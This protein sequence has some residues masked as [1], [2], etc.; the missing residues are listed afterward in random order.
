MA[1]D[2][3]E[4]FRDRVR[5]VDEALEARLPSDASAPEKVHEAMRYAVFGGGKRLRPM[6]LLAATEA[7]GHRPEAFFEAACAVELAHTTSLILDD[8][9]C[10]DDAALR[11]GRPC[12]HKKYGD[13]TAILAA[14]ALLSESFRLVARNA[15]TLGNPENAAEAVALLDEALGTRGLVAGQELDLRLTGQEAPLETIMRVHAQKAGALF[16]AAIRLPAVLTG[17]GSETGQ[18]LAA[19]AAPVGLAFQITDDLIDTADP[20]EDAGKCTFVRL[21]GAEGARSRV[22]ALIEEAISAISPFG[23]RAECLRHLARYV[24]NRQV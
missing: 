14:I 19:Y 9:P 23:E 10:M 15:C 4:M 3:L 20:N 11:R 22:D 6:A 16:V 21:L 1:A 18:R 24:R 7:L 5:R 17:A 8:L 13:S 2:M 12:T